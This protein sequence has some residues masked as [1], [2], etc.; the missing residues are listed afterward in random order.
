[1]Y[2]PCYPVRSNGVFC[3]GAFAERRS[4]LMALSQ[5]DKKLSR[6]AESKQAI[7]IRGPIK[8]GVKASRF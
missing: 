4:Q 7:S 8:G 5:L 2:F 1:M 3:T 6:M